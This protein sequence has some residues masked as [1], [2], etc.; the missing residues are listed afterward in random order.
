MI[1]VANVVGYVS[2]ERGIIPNDVAG[3]VLSGR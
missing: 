2:A 3:T 1:V